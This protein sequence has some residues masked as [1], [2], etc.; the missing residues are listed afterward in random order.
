MQNQGT[1]QDRDI[2]GHERIV[3]D[4]GIGA[5]LA[6]LAGREPTPGG[7]AVAARQVAYGAA[8]VAM[9]GRFAARDADS[10]EV[11]AVVSLADDACARAVELAAADEAAFGAVAA[12][13]QLPRGTDQEQQA[14][15]AAIAAALV[16]ASRPPADVIELAGEAM[17]LAERIA[18]LASRSTLAD[19][20]AAVEVLRAAV[21][22]SRLNVETNLRGLDLAVVPEALTAS[23]ATS[24]DTVKRADVCAEEI[25]RRLYRR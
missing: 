11:A 9:V 15:S 5:F 2:G 24:G 6:R 8:L 20:A 10:D 18:P 7:G 21:V 22:T 17:G 3:P 4:E 23:A 13:L 1:G 14:R 19:L 25:R 12:A 16:E